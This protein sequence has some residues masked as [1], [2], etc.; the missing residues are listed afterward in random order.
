MELHDEWN[1]KDDKER[2]WASNDQ[3]NVE[4]GHR[5]IG[6][7][8]A[9]ED[10]CEGEFVNEYDD[11][12][13]NNVDDEDDD[14]EDYHGIPHQQLEQQQGH[15]T[16][17]SLHNGSSQ[18]ETTSFAEDG[19]HY[20]KYNRGGMYAKSS[21]RKQVLILRTNLNTQPKKWLKQGIIKWDTCRKIEAVAGLTKGIE[22]LFKKNK[23][24]YVQGAGKIVSGSEV[25]GDPLDREI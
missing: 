17:Q 11:D 13:E 25:S 8:N 12:E 4:D 23:V 16:H 10:E 1:E 6:L 20:Y 21:M 24:T 9:N 2:I 18:I 7:T 5:L 14:M 19:R 15:H 3:R 22:G